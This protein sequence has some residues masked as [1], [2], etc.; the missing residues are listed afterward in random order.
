M[1]AHPQL[2]GLQSEEVLAVSRKNFWAP[3][4]RMR[5]WRS[6]FLWAAFKWPFER[7]VLTTL[8]VRSYDA[9]F[10]GKVKQGLPVTS[11][12]IKV[13][14]QPAQRIGDFGTIVVNRTGDVADFVEAG[15]ADPDG[16]AQARLSLI[17]K[18]AFPAIL[19]RHKS[20]LFRLK[21]IL[22]P[23]ILGLGMVYIMLALWTN[24]SPGLAI[25]FTLMFVV[26]T[27]MDLVKVDDEQQML[28]YQQ[29]Y[30][31][32]LKDERWPKEDVDEETS[33]LKPSAGI[34][35]RRDVLSKNWVRAIVVLLMAVIVILGALSL[36]NPMLIL[37]I[38]VAMLLTYLFALVYPY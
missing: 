26:S 33:Y 29:A 13:T 5:L 32:L 12:D 35:F 34:I 18:T 8:N 28:V 25:V 19:N 2:S 36:T 16:F 17:Q 20:F 9:P 27:I 4:V 14:Q 30:D 15:A 10:L 24:G 38:L 7:A 1:N 6:F 3:S 21:G 22:V 37:A 11:V 23:L 31:R